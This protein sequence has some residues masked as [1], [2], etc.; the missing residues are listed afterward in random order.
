MIQKSASFI[1]P[2]LGLEYSD[3]KRNGFQTTYLGDAR[4]ADW[5]STLGQ[6]LYVEL[7]STCSSTYLKELTQHPQYSNLRMDG[8]SY[9]IEF[10]IPKKWTTSVVEKFMEGKYSEIDR[11]YV[12]TNFPKY[13]SSASESINYKILTKSKELKEYWET[14]LDV[15]L[16]PDAEVWSIPELKDEIKYYAE[17]VV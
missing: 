12:K 2:T 3:L 17:E 4:L 1:L 9:L 14:I 13:T 11:D 5:K 15:E 8:D 16:D 6:K 7:D 10:D